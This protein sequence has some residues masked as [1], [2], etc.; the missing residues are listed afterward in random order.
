LPH[1][2]VYYTYERKK[3]HEEYWKRAIESD[4]EY[5][6]KAYVSKY[7]NGKYHEEFMFKLAEKLNSLESYE[8]YRTLYPHGK[9]LIEYKFNIARITRD[10]NLV[11]SLIREYEST[12]YENEVRLL[13]FMINNSSDKFIDSRDGNI[14]RTIK[15]GNQVWMSENLRYKTENSKSYS[16][17]VD[18]QCNYGEIYDSL[19][20]ISVCPHGWHLPARNEWIA[21]IDTLLGYQSSVGCYDYGCDYLKSRIGWNNRFNGNDCVGFTAYPTGYI[22]VN[23]INGKIEVYRKGI[24]AYWWALDTNKLTYWGLHSLAEHKLGNY[25]NIYLP[26]R[27]IKN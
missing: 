25:T 19:D 14:Y 11:D 2:I 15:I 9:Y 6:Y 23:H 1:I 7:P 16:E 21:L 10:R 27:C 5:D 20:A 17:I 13:K 3:I 18:A 12:N 26:I 4:C 24:A 8:N 22:E